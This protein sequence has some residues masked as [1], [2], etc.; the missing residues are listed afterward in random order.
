MHRILIVGAVAEQL[1][2]AVVRDV[3]ALSQ[4]PEAARLPLGVE[5]VRGDLTRP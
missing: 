5:V 3:R 1:I 4:D 2:A